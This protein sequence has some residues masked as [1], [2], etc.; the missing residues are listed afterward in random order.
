ME[1]DHSSDSNFLK[2]YL[3]DSSGGIIG[4]ELVEENCSK[5]YSNLVLGC[6]RTRVVFENVDDCSSLPI[7]CRILGH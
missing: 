5:F 2:N 7:A 4:V 6:G 3:K 1:L